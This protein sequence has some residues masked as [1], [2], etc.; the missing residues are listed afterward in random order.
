VLRRNLWRE[1][2]NAPDCCWRFPLVPI[3]DEVKTRYLSAAAVALLLAGCAHATSSS[4]TRTHTGS[5]ADVTRELTELEHDWDAAGDRGDTATINRIVA[6]EYV[7]YFGNGSIDK[8][9]LLREVAGP[10]EWTQAASDAGVKN[11]QLYDNVA[12]LHGLGTRTMRSRTGQLRTDRDV[13]I[14]VFVHR[15]GRWQIVTGQYTAVG[16]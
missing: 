1:Y 12:I 16:R 14:E 9:S 6:D 15:D 4:S 5:V 8:K 7:G 13:Y 11:V 3:E 2:P 10:H